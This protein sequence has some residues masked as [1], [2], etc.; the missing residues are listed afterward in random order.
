M[1][2]MELGSDRFWELS[3]STEHSSLRQ[4]PCCNQVPVCYRLRSSEKLTRSSVLHIL[5]Y[6]FS[7]D[8]HLST[9]EVADLARVHKDTLLRWL[10]KGKVEEPARDFRGWRVFTKTEALAI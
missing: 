2:R 5:A 9:Q 7:M 10:R 3:L 4:L 6:T 8:D 1:P